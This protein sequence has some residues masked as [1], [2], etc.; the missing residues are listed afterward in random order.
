MIYQIRINKKLRNIKVYTIL[1]KLGGGETFMTKFFMK[2]FKQQ[3]RTD[4]T[5][6]SPKMKG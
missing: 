5:W 2:L 6:Q 3:N 1:R 4:E